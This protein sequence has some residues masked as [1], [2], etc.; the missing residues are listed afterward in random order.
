M[1]RFA[2]ASTEARKIIK[3]EERCIRFLD[4]KGFIHQKEFLH[5]KGT[6]CDA[7]RF[8][9]ICAGMFSM[10]KTY[11]ERELSP[12]FDDP[13]RRD[14]RRCWA[15]S[16]RRSCWRGCRR[17]AAGARRPSSRRS[18]NGSRRCSG[19][20]EHATLSVRQPAA[21]PRRGLHRLPVLRQPRPA[22]LRRAGGAR[23]ARRSRCTTPS[24]C[25]AS[26]RHRARRR[27]LRA[28]RRARR[29][30]RRPARRGLR[31]RRAR[32]LGLP[33]HRSGARRDAAS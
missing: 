5:G 7:C 15:T 6:A 13:H 3:E 2:W 21:R 22:R 19:R 16:R 33:A 30:H 26:G 32:R 17:G 11:D 31:R 24:P 25:P 8:D 18:R 14:R 28:R 29:L 9:P 20:C 27:R 23:R 10:A 1:R 12:I 4:Y